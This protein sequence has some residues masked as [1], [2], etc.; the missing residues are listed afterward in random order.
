MILPGTEPQ[1]LAQAAHC[2]KDGGL[3]GMPTE[4]VYGL[5]ADACQPGAVAQVF[6]SKGRPSDHPLIVHVRGFGQVDFFASEV[7]EFARRLMAAFWPGPL[8]LILPRRAGVAAQAAGGQ[9]TVGLRCPSHPVAQALL[10]QAL[11]LGVRGVAAPSANRFGRVSPTTA[12]HVVQELGLDL[13]V[14][15]GGACAVGIEST[16]VDCSRGMPV[17]LR[18][19]MLSLSALS[20]AAGQTV[21]PAMAPHA[22]P[23]PKASG[24]LQAHYAPRATVRLLSTEQMQARLHAGGLPVGAICAVWSRQPMAGPGL[25]HHPMPADPARAAQVLFAWL[26]QCDDAGVA[27]IWVEPPPPDP[28]WDGVRDRLQRAAAAAL[29]HQPDNR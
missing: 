28:A 27:E 11:A 21:R 19:G 10:Q 16:I 20:E 24:T 13:L 6:A 25:Q 1:A 22:Q 5:A 18:P 17:M 15:D 29:P 7:P 8:T 4:T 23:A 3:V 14:L 12:A 9:A 26:R 2:L